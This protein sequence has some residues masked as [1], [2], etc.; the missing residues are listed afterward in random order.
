MTRI[1]ARR[2]ISLT[3][4]LFLSKS[5]VAIKF[6]IGDDRYTAVFSFR[7]V[8]GLVDGFET[9]ERL[10]TRAFDRDVRDS[11]TWD[12]PRREPSSSGFRCTRRC[13]RRHWNQPSLYL[14]GVLACRRR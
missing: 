11:G 10:R 9:R 3:N 6:P 8:E 5:F 1:K 14:E 4:V 13:V 7:I 12:K 2:W